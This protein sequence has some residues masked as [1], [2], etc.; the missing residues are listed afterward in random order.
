MEPPVP[1][2]SRP[3]PPEIDH[4]VLFILTN[5]ITPLREAVASA[6]LSFTPVEVIAV[7]VP[8]FTTHPWYPEL[9]YVAPEFPKR[10]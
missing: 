7:N 10:I 1:V 5:V 3:I 6:E 8:L 2:S 9:K 4:V